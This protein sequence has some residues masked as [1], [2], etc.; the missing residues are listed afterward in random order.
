MVAVHHLFLTSL[1]EALRVNI[2]VLQVTEMNK[3]TADSEQ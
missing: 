2:S 3:G 1:C